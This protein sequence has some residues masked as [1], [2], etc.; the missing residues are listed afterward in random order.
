MREGLE[1]F[2]AWC[3]DVITNGVDPD[4]NRQKPFIAWQVRSIIIDFVDST[5]R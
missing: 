3:L 2:E 4:D 1:F 5:C